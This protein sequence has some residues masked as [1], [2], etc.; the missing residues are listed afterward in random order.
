MRKYPSAVIDRWLK[1]N[2]TGLPILSDLYKKTTVDRYG[3][4]SFPTL[5]VIDTTG[6]IRYAHSGY[7]EGDEAAVDAAVRALLD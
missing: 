5:L 1:K 7:K 2:P 6:V 3:L 4:T